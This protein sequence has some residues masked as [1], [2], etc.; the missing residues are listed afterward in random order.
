MVTRYYRAPEIMYGS[1]DYS[2]EVDI[3]SLG[4][5]I[6]E[7]ILESPLFPG[8]TDIDQLDKIYSV[9][10]SPLKTWHEAVNYPYFM[11]FDVE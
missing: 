5:T 11:D 4:C 3:W 6:A 1:N 10:G 7:L 9:M 8:Q 2:F